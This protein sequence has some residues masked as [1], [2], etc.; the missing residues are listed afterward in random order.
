MDPADQARAIIPTGVI[1]ASVATG[2]G[3]LPGVG[4][5]DEPVEPGELMAL[6]WPGFGAVAALLLDRDP[7]SRLGRVLAGTALVPVLVVSVAASAPLE[8]GPETRLETVW[9]ATGIV[10]LLATIA[11]VGWAMGVAPDRLS[12][13][14]MAWFAAWAGL[15]VAAVVVSHRVSSPMGAAVTTMVGLWALICS[16]TLLCTASELRPIDEPLL[17]AAAAVGVLAVGATAGLL[18]RWAGRHGHI[19]S[20]DVTGGF[21]AAIAGAFA[22]PGAWWARN[23]YLEHRYGTGELSSDDLASL[24]TG[25]GTEGDPR[26]LLSQVAAMVAAASGHRGATIT[27]GDDEPDVPGHWVSHTLVV[28]LDRVGTLAL[29][30]LHEEGPEPRQRR[31]VAQL[32]PTV[33]L[34]T[35]AVVLA[36]GAEHSRQDLVRERDAERARILADLHDGLG[37]VLAGLRMRLQARLRAEPSE[38]LEEAVDD[39]AAIRDELRLLVQGLT[40][41]VLDDGNLTDALTCLVE[42]FRA[43]GAAVTLDV[44]PDVLPPPEAAVALYRFVAEG[45]TNAIRH[46]GATGITVRVGQGANGFEASVADDGSGGVFAP[47]VGLTSLRRRAGDLGG[48]LSIERAEPRGTLLKMAL[49]A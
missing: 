49:P 37:P 35:R 15:V 27:L 1:L 8:G 43:G 11:V 4:A 5:F 36:I 22:V 17:D 33:S 42:S 48:S 38:W 13:R 9:R 47:G 7:G 31:I 12:R 41:P 19:P 46:A 24:T 10:P 25:L 14:R 18:M 2:V 6:G 21:V 40:P 29:N 20:P 3:F 28:G 45:I 23:R 26:H 30:P 34:A 44:A 32:L 16:L 39:L